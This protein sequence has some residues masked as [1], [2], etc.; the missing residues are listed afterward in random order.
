MATIDLALLKQLYLP[1]QEFVQVDV[2]EMPFLMID[3]EGSPQHATFTDSIKWLFAVAFPIKQVARQRM[4]RDFVEPPLECLW[5]AD[6]LQDLI[7]GHKDKFKWRLM[8][9][10]PDWLEEELFQQ[11]VAAAT[12]KL[13]SVSTV[14]PSLR[15][16]RFREGTCVQIMHVGPNSNEPAVLQQLHHEYLPAH[17]LTATGHH[18]EIYLNDPKRVAPEKL[19]TVLRQPV[20]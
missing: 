20:C 7:A 8:I 17:H 6:D 5:W 12:E 18:H 14:P 19:K 4:G 11:A 1:P 9:P 16:E 10:A 3:G 15:L 2:P 13:A